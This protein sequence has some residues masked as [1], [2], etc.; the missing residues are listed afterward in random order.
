MTDI[1]LGIRLKADSSGM[2]G[3]LKSAKDGLKD[4]G[5]TASKVSG[6]A[7]KLNAEHQNMART[8][9]DAAGKADNFVARLRAEAE[10]LGFTSLQVKAYAASKMQLNDAQARS[11]AASLTAIKMHEDERA[12]AEKASAMILTAGKALAAFAAAKVALT[13][14]SVKSVLAEADDINKE[15]QAL[16]VYAEWL[17]KVRYSGELANVSSD[18]LRL[19]LRNLT[20][21]IKEAENQTGNG[22]RIFSAMGI[23]V[24][25]VTGRVRT[26]D[27]LLPEL[28][29]KFQS[30]ADGPRK[31][32]L[33]LEI[34]GRD[35]L[36]WV[37]LLNQ[38]SRGL[39]ENAEEAQRLGL[40]IGGDLARKSEAF[41]DNV[42]RLEGAWR[43]LKVELTTGVLP[44][45]SSLIEKM[46]EAYRLSG[47]FVGAMQMMANMNSR[48][49][50]KEKLDMYNG[51]IAGGGASAGDI[52]MR[53]QLAK[54]YAYQ[55]FVQR[56]QALS[57][58]TPGTRDE[59]AR[60]GSG[61]DAP[62]IPKA[63]NSGSG[64]SDA[65][66][67]AGMLSANEHAL[68]ALNGETSRYDD[69]L[70][71]LIKTGLLWKDVRSLDLLAAEREYDVKKKLIAETARQI[72]MYDALAKAEA[73]QHATYTSMFMAMSE[74]AKGLADETKLIGLSKRARD[75]A[76]ES[77]KLEN[78]YYA[79]RNKLQDDDIRGHNELNDATARA[80]AALPG[81]VAARSAAQE[82]DEAI[83]KAA[84]ESK[85]LIDDTGRGITD[86]IMRG[87]A[88][89]W[90][91][92][93]ETFVNGFKNMILRPIIQPIMT[94]AA[95]SV[96]GLMGITG[97]ANASSGGGGGSIGNLL[98]GAN[99]IFGGGNP[100]GMISNVF[101]GSGVGA[102]TSS[103]VLTAAPVFE[104]GAMVA[105][106]E[107][108]SLAS[109]AGMSA[110][111]SGIAA[112]IPYVGI[113]LAAASALGL[114][115]GGGGGPATATGGDF[116]GMASASGLSGSWFGS[117]KNSQEAFHF[118]LPYESTASNPL[119]AGVFTD[120]ARIAEALGIDAARIADKSYPFSFAFANSLPQGWTGDDAI[121]GAK[122]HLSALTDQIAMDLMPNL[123]KF[124]QAG[125][126]ATQTLV[127]LAAEMQNAKLDN[128]FGMMGGAIQLQDQTRDLWLSDLSPLTAT[129][130]FNA[131]NARYA[132]LLGQSAT[133]PRAMNELSGFVRSNLSEAASYYGTS[134]PEYRALFEGRQADVGNLVTDTLT[135]QSIQ[136]AEMGLTMKDIAANTKDM[137]K[138]IAAA[139][140][141]AIDAWQAAHV[142]VTQAAA[143]QVSDAVNSSAHNTAFSL[144]SARLAQFGGGG[145]A[146]LESDSGD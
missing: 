43:G 57:L 115:G 52:K 81:L 17:S 44:T 146:V 74:Q 130:R 84:Q 121:A 23:A 15:A 128:I 56:Q 97:N 76:V 26:L 112:A 78:A 14:V 77:M 101:G 19:G 90:K 3:E 120:M 31:T 45:L 2:I 69:T 105:G 8:M 20:Q 125:E 65:K 92:L 83:K 32:A 59:T 9:S 35:G 106:A 82:A 54:D 104:A 40:V 27:N 85:S 133:D 28:A 6:E 34:F 109:T 93:R 60:Y 79:A 24:T 102:I 37:P 10:T 88:D 63:P 7:A 50:T 127:R 110:V 143:T 16:G 103:G 13:I 142:A 62:I 47:S 21:Q 113:A 95:G 25:D 73:D 33:A 129:E 22:G 108:A 51:F 39:A 118:Q 136:F 18:Q 96:L 99:T 94:S 49:G 138:R 4:F 12:S 66:M 64:E 116:S 134:T 48:E 86:A 11:V 5:D 132:E 123:A 135:E 119:I 145:D 107:F 98:S 111:G 80:R 42:T 58:W 137:D 140:T 1:V 36:R 68:R 46:N 71:K 87:G 126:T 61:V 144:L 91:N 131:S 55:Q 67:L 72:Q 117:A 141:N 38:G 53:D 114:F 89:G 100:W 30:Y 75:L 29:D 124:A 122:A 139:L 70:D 41:R